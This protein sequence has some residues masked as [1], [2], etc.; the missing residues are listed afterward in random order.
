MM[1][2]IRKYEELFKDL[3]L[4]HSDF[5]IHNFVLGEEKGIT[6]WGKYKQALRELHKRVRG[7]KQLLFQME[8]DKIEI[9]KIKRKIE[10]LKKGKYQ[11]YDLD[12]KL[13][14]INLAEKQTNL[15]IAEKSLQELLREAEEFYKVVVV[16]KEKFKNLSKEDKW[17]LEKEYWML[18][19]KRDIE[20][21]L[22]AGQKPSFGLM[23]VIKSL[24]LDMQK[25]LLEFYGNAEVGYG[26]R[27]RRIL[28]LVQENLKGFK[29]NGLFTKIKDL[30]KLTRR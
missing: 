12:V 27:V 22:L 24:P 1:K 20:D 6:E 30:F 10:R 7:V 17:R 23:R 5:Q 26:L 8:R 11:D 4:A 3:E 25:E 28:S 14:E 21:S 15:K 9:E 18:K 19:F 13:E 16:L 2:D 29:R